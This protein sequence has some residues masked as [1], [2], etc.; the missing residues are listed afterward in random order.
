MNFDDI[1]E[2]VITLLKRQGRVSYN[3]LRRRFEI[4][5]AYLNDLK[6]EILYV[7]PVI[8][9]EGR[10]LIWTGETEVTPVT[11]SQPEQ[12]EPQPVVEQTQPVQEISTVVELHTPE[13]ERRQLTVMFCDLVDSTRLSGQL[14]PEDYR[15]VLRDY[16]AACTQVVSV[17]KVTS[18]NS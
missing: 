6:E 18:P 9:D 2:Q 8:D 1:L 3:A 7:H 10:G 11:T 15:D 17:L 12:P 13:A 4:D 14:D 5:E 16:Q